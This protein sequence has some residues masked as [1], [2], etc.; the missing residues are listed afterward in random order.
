MP[1]SWPPPCST[2]T[3]S[4]PL[5]STR[6]PTPIGPPIL[7]PDSVRASR[8]L[9]AKSTGRW[10]TAC[11]ASECTGM[12]CSAHRAATSAT[13]CTVPTSLLAHITDTS[14][15]ASGSFADLG[16]QGVDVDPP[17]GVDRQPDELGV[18][19]LAEP[20]RGVDDG[21]VLDR[22]EQHLAAAGVL[23]AALPVQALGGEVVGLR[24]AGGQHHLVGCGPD[25]GRQPLPRL[26]HHAAR[27]A[28]RGVQGGGV[29]ARREL[30]GEGLQGER[31]DR[32]G[33]R[34]VEVDRR[35]TEGRCHDLSLG[36]RPAALSSSAVP[37]SPWTSR[38]PRWPAGAP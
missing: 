30:L 24:A 1:R 29:A 7:W 13:G 23:G 33:R 19:V 10:P 31:V 17:L 22:A 21:V 15:T 9:A 14:A 4:S 38:R 27:A 12:P 32:G 37:L 18:L 3:R 8:P 5:R 28:P 11:T 25:G 36:R 26:L 35:R 2:G 20:D 16:A 34:V 6:A